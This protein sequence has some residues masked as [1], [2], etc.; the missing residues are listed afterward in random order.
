MADLDDTSK[1]YD[2]P[3]PRKSKIIKSYELEC[4]FYVARPAASLVSEMLRNL[5]PLCISLINSTQYVY[6]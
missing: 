4:T 3:S 1:N 2:T 6:R 5:P